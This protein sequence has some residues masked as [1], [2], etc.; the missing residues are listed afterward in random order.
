[1]EQRCYEVDLEEP[2]GPHGPALGML[3]GW[4]REKKGSRKTHLEIKTLRQV[5]ILYLPVTRDSNPQ[6]KDWVNITGH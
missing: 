3:T 5:R 1:M 4:L 2:G 6:L